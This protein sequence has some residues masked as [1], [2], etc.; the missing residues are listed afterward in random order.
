MFEL[1]EAPL[2]IFLAVVAPIWIIAHYVTRWRTAKILT[3]EDESMLSELWETAPKLESRIN[4]L[5]S[6]LDAE[7]PEWRKQ[8]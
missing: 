4:A 2:I 7:A 6:I 3:T 8:I 5:E 1:L